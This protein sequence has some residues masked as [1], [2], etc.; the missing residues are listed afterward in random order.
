MGHHELSDYVRCLNEIGWGRTGTVSPLG[1]FTCQHKRPGLLLELGK[2]VIVDY[3]I[4]DK[5]PEGSGFPAFGPPWRC[6]LRAGRTRKSLRRGHSRVATGQVWGGGCPDALATTLCVYIYISVCVCM[7]I[8]CFYKHTWHYMQA[9]ETV[10]SITPTK[11]ALS[12]SITVCTIYLYIY[13]YL[14]V[15]TYLDTY[16]YISK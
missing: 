15:Y 13:I 14:F 1:N 7:Y 16:I 3:N 5:L 8:L 11:L 2:K 9:C 4:I 12:I 10:S 6:S